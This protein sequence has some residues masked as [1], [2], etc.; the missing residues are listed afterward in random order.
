MRGFCTRT[1]WPRGELNLP[2]ALITD[3][4]YP[5]D[6]AVITTTVNARGPPASRPRPYTSS[7]LE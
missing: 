4:A 5:E 1:S 3:K 6:E 2:R 7:A